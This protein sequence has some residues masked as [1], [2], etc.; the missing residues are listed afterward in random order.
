MHLASLLGSKFSILIGR[1]KWLSRM[2]NDAKACGSESRITSWR[3]QN[4]SVSDTA[5][6]E[7]T[8]AAAVK[9][10]EAAITEDG[11]EVI[12]FG[13]TDLCGIASDLQERLDVPV[14]DPVIAGLKFAELSADLREKAGISHSKIYSYESPP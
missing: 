6:A 13:R 7:K 10:G 2:E 14:I 3:I 5:D 4:L 11:T 12:V 1:R 9:E 8:K